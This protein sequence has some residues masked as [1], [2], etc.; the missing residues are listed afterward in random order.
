VRKMRTIDQLKHVKVVVVT[1]RTHLQGQLSDTMRLTGEQVD[2]VKTVRETKRVLA[3][4][5]PGIVFVMIQQQ[6]DIGKREAMREEGLLAEKAPSLGELNADESIV[7]LIDEAH[8]SHSSA[9]HNNLLDALPNCARIGFTGT[10]I[11]MGK[12]RKS[13]EIFGP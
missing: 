5:G 2:A 4:H 8:R 3:E 12:K 6:Q 7:V 9:L 10:P 11:I 1:D 13:T